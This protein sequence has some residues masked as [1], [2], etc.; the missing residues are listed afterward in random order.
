[1]RPQGSGQALEARRRQ[2][3][4]LLDAGYSLHA[5]A[6]AIGCAA[7]SVLRWRDRRQRGG[8]AALKVR[9]APGRPPKLEAAQ[10]QRLVQV[11][12]RGARAQGYATGGWTTARIAAVIAQQFGVQYHRDHIGRL[13]QRLPW[14]PVLPPRPGRRPARARPARRAAPAAAAP[15]ASA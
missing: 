6:R 8:S 5:V 10:R 14:Q 7:S 1:M 3:L 12:Q 11:L 13:L 15:P 9:R 2:A 4:R